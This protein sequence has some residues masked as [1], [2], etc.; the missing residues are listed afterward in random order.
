MQNLEAKFGAAWD[1]LSDYTKARFPRWLPVRQKF[2]GTSIRDPDETMIQQMDEPQIRGKIKPGDSVAVAVGSRGIAVLDHIVNVLIRKLLEWEAIPCIVPAMGSHGGGTAAGQRHTLAS[3]GIDEESTGVSIQSSL[4]VV[5]LGRVDKG[6]VVYLDRHADKANHIIPVC[7]IKPHTGFRGSHESGALKLLSVGL[8]NQKGAAELHSYG[9]ESF[10]RNLKKAGIFILEN[11][12]IPFAVCIVENAHEKIACLEIIPGE[13][14]LEREPKLLRMS[15]TL[16]GKL[17][18]NE[19]DVLI[20]GQ[21]GKNISGAGLDPN[22]TGR[23][24]VP[25]LQGG[26]D[27][28]K[29]VVLDLTQESDGNGIGIGMADIISA[30][31]MDKL[32]V[33]AMYLNAVTSSVLNAPKIPVVMKND[34]DAVALA[35]NTCNQKKLRDIRIVGIPNTSDLSVVYLSEALWKEN[36]ER[37]DLA[38]T[39]SM[40]A[41]EFGENGELFCLHP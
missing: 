33:G 36:L 28:R 23:Y 4:E 17:P 26:A 5:K 34:R 22:V 11:K 21:I 2:S 3:L 8:G 27:V 7:R 35:I 1:V 31:V 37:A 13:R 9:M 30:A 6:P 32:N 18:V 19:I 25:G 38:A 12:S 29:L 24:S 39:D 10:A 14:L 40:A 16:M 41:M 15:R 20:V